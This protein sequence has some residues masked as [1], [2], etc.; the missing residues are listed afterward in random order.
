LYFLYSLFLHR[1]FSTRRILKKFLSFQPRCRLLDS[2]AIA[3]HSLFPMPG[4]L[5]AERS[6]A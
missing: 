3:A 5:T 4:V 1:F 2:Q 6:A